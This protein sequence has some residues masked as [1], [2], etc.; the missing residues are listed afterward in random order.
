MKLILLL[1][2]LLIVGLLVNKQLNSSSPNTR[3]GDVADSEDVIVPKIPV[4]PEDVPK[5]EKEMK[6]FIMD[7]ADKRAKKIE[8]S[9]ND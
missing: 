8:E 1:I 4:V 2:A 6:D 5:F 3:Y 9:L 7:S